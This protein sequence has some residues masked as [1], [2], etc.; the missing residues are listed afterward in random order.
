MKKIVL[1]I[2]FVLLFGFVGS[3]T[4][5]AKTPEDYNLT[6]QKTL[7][8]SPYYSFKRLKEKALMILKINTQS[9]FEY[10]KSLM[11]K[12]LSEL[13]SLVAVKD[14][15]MIV[16]ASQRFSY[17][18]GVTR[19]LNEK[20]KESKKEELAQ[21]FDNYSKILAELRDNYPSNSPNWLLTQQN[22]DTLKILLSEM[23]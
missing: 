5:H 6:N 8:T 13:T 11:E 17:Q 1:G 7:P 18:A 12:R 15:N 21:L 22:I 2:I 4:L 3:G 10:S 19:S 16:G 23:K 20:L 14:P 9:K